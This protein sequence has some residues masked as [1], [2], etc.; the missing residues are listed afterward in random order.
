M[1]NI[2]VI[3]IV[4]LLMA[5]AIRYMVRNRNKGCAGCSGSSC[6]SHCHAAEKMIRDIN[7]QINKD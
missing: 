2:I 1:G 3:A 4:V 7:A 6:C 5:L